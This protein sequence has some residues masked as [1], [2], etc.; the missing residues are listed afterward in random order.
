MV[1]DAGAL[2]FAGGFLM[3]LASSLHCASMCGGVASAMMF[4]FAASDTAGARQLALGLT[5]AGRAAGYVLAGGA[6]ATIGAPVISALDHAGGLIA[7]RWASAAM[8]AWIGLATLGLVPPLRVLHGFAARLRLPTSYVAGAPGIVIWAP[9]LSGLGWSFTP[10]PMVLAA[11]V[12]AGLSGTSLSGMQVMAGFALGTMPAVVACAL[13][14]DR[15]RSAAR[16]PAARI[17]V[18]LG[19]V[20]LGLASAAAPLSGGILGLCLTSF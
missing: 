17:S 16:R 14:M 7:L 15:L 9:F 8:L 12:Y 19:L 4:S 20:G 10:C 3:G 1:G 18:G 5:Q 6:T 11:L 13:G 2:T